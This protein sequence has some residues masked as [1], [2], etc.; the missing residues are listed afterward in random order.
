MMINSEEK[1][2]K[3]EEYHNLKGEPGLCG[4]YVIS[5]NARVLVTGILWLP[6]KE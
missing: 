4:V 5:Q 6:L 1:K 3:V 2:I